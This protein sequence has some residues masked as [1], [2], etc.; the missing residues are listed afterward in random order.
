MV[1]VSV[2]RAPLTRHRRA[3]SPLSSSCRCRAIRSSSSLTPPPVLKP[4]PPPLPPPPPPPP[5]R[6]L[7]GGSSTSSS[8]SSSSSSM[9]PQPCAPVSSK[10]A[11][12]SLSLRAERCHREREA[13]GRP[14]RVVRWGAAC[15]STA[16]R[17][18]CSSRPSATDPR[19]RASV[20]MQRH[21]PGTAPP[22]EAAHLDP[23]ARLRR[24]LAPRAAPGRRYGRRIGLV[25]VLVLAAVLARG[26]LLA[27]ARLGLL[28][29]L[30]AAD[31]AP[32]ARLSGA[33]GRAG[34]GRGRSNQVRARSNHNK[35]RSTPCSRVSRQRW[36]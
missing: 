31:A 36:P 22:H 24:R 1:H 29:V 28:L 26:V 4:L 15:R 33:P 17:C 20:A 7:G 23:L 14:R 2:C 5:R 18:G 25:R 8:S 11:A 12:S 21:Q 35:G 34:R 9:L 27:A 30:V 13:A 6:R 10:K 16:K 19:R 3:L 32:L